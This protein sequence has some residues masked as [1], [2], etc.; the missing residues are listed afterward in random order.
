MRDLQK[1]AREDNVRA[2]LAVDVLRHRAQVHRRLRH[3]RHDRVLGGIAE[4][5]VA[6]RG[7]IVERLTTLGIKLDDAANA[8]RGEEVR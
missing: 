4:N 3:C 8:A 5:G 7:S 2:K 6:F 1:A